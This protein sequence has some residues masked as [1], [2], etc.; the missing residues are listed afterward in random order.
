MKKKWIIPASL[1]FIVF[2][3]PIC[4]STSSYTHHFESIV[5]GYDTIRSVDKRHETM[6]RGMQKSLGILTRYESGLEKR[7]GIT[8]KKIINLGIYNRYKFDFEQTTKINN[9]KI[10]TTSSIVA[11][12]WG[13]GISRFRQV[14]QL[15]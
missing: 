10:K 14:Y 2:L 1:I 3:S 15:R 8:S 9:L 7:L 12:N 5:D 11:S 13:I 4:F 6:T